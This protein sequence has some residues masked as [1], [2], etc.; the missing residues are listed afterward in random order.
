MGNGV[1]MS[2]RKNLQG[3]ILLCLEEQSA[4]RYVYYDCIYAKGRKAKMLYL[5]LCINVLRTVN[6]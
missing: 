2:T 1:G 6:C 5:C 4:E 3:N